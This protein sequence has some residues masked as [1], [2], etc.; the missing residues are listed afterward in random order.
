[1]IV[2]EPKQQGGLREQVQVK[3]MLVTSNQQP[4]Q[5]MLY[6]WMSVSASLLLM[7]SSDGIYLLEDDEELVSSIEKS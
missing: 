6:Q 3:E 4:V 7:S 5:E 2:V 1:M